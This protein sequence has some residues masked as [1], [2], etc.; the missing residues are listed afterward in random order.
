MARLSAFDARDFAQLHADEIGMKIR[1][2]RGFELDVTNSW[3]GIEVASRAGVQDTRLELD[4]VQAHA[5]ELPAGL[6]SRSGPGMEHEFRLTEASKQRFKQLQ[7]F[8]SRGKAED[9]NI[10]VVPKLASA[11]ATASAVTVWIDLRLSQRDGYF[12]LVDGASIPLPKG[13][14]TER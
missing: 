8:L 7:A 6:L 13:K 4:P 1:I 14:G 9:V 2:P 11:P 10:R 5:I 12:A 3:L